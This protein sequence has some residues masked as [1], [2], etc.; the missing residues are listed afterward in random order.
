MRIPTAP[1]DPLG[2]TASLLH[3]LQVTEKYIRSLQR[4]RMFKRRCLALVVNMPSN[5]IWALVCA[6]FFLPS[7]E[8]FALLPPV[9]VMQTVVCWFQ[10]SAKHREAKLALTLTRKAEH[11]LPPALP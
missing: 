9:S 3:I 8:Q 2:L 7:R 5:K 1:V 11:D 4:L 10:M 6:F